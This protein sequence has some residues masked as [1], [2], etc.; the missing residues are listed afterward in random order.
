LNASYCHILHILLIYDFINLWWSQLLKKILFDI[1]II[2]LIQIQSDNNISL[3][4]KLN[5]AKTLTLENKKKMAQQAKPTERRKVGALLKM[6]EEIQKVWM[7]SKAFEEDAPQYKCI[8]GN[9]RLFY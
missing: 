6:E 5:S 9:V 1:L 2:F 3:E 7:D 8:F 4:G